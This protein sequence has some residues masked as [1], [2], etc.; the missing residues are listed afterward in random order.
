MKSFRK[1]ENGANSVDSMIA[2]GMG[3]EGYHRKAV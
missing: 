3:D 2:R 1:R